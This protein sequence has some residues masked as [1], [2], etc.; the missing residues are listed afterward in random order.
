MEAEVHERRVPIHI[1][2]PDE[3]PVT[4][5]PLVASIF[6]NPII[7]H[8]FLVA[9]LL[10][11][12]RHQ[13]LAPGI[14]PCH[15]RVLCVPHGRAFHVRVHVNPAPVRV[16]VL[17]L[18]ARHLLL[19]ASIRMRMSLFLVLS[20]DEHILRL[21]TSIPVLMTFILLLAADKHVFRLVTPV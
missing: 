13:V 3:L 11:R 8:A 12:R 10:L 6:C 17:L 18:F 16:Y 9:E 7:F 15:V 19:V 21:E 1:N 2:V 14:G 20:A 4:G 5:I